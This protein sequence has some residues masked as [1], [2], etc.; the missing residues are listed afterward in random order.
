[1]HEANKSIDVIMTTLGTQHDREIN[2]YRQRIKFQVTNSCVMTE[3]NTKIE[4]LITAMG[5][6]LK[7]PSLELGI[8]SMV[9]NMTESFLKEPNSKATKRKQEEFDHLMALRLQE[10]EVAKN[11]NKTSP[12]KEPTNVWSYL[13]S[14]LKDKDFA[15]TNMHDPR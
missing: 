7:K 2:G 1:M 5:E 12:V 11:I 14:N 8:H 15:P 3:V 6:F 9:E 10:E 4:E 13:T